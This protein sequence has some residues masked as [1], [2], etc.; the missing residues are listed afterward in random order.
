MTEQRYA[1][2][3]PRGSAR[4]LYELMQPVWPTG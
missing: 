3:V 2:D 4:E 1:A